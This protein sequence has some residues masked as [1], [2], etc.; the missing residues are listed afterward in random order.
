MIKKN[1]K[2]I[3]FYTII[4]VFLISHNANS[5]NFISN[6][7]T[8]ALSFKEMQLQ[9]HQYKQNNNLNSKKYW[10]VFKRYESEMQL[11]TNANGEPDGFST[12]VD[13]AL[14]A[15]GAKSAGS[16]SSPWYPVGPNAVPGNLTGY[17]ENG[18]GRVNCVAFSPTNTNIF[19][20]MP[21]AQRGYLPRRAELPRG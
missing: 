12:Y 7:G 18:I 9:F 17:M 5:Q 19:Y 3:L 21:A 1:T 16:S 11:H 8:K 14:K 20:V 10:K 6:P 2:S 15:A 13:E 4:I